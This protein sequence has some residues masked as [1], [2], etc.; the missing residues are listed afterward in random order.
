MNDTQEKLT[1]SK[2]GPGMYRV[3]GWSFDEE[4]MSLPYIDSAIAAWTEWR[5]YVCARIEEQ[6]I[7]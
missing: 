1:V 4:D 6:S 3:G 2:E 5:A 7:D